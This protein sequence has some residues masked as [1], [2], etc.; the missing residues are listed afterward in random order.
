MLARNFEKGMNL[1]WRYLS[2]SHV[3]EQ[4]DPCQLAAF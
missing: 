3:T 4:C 2:L 1:H